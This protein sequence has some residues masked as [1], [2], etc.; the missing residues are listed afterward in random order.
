MLSAAFAKRCDRLRNSVFHTQSLPGFPLQP[1][2]GCDRSC[3]SKCLSARFRSCNSAIQPLTV[4]TI[5]RVLCSTDFSPSA[6]REL[7]ES[8]ARFAF[9]IFIDDLIFRPTPF[10]C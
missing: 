8:S 2:S 7:F 9:M 3:D 1:D 4:L 10:L 6:V 5:A